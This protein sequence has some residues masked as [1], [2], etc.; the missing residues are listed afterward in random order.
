MSHYHTNAAGAAGMYLVQVAFVIS[1]L[2]QLLPLHALPPERC[3]P[4]LRSLL[5]ACWDHDPA[6]RPAA[7][8]V[9]KVLALVKEVCAGWGG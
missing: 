8:E 1:V 9:V 5:R 4:K 7:A 3:P 2:K 6:R